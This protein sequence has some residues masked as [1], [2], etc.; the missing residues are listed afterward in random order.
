MTDRPTND[1]HDPASAE[2]EPASSPCLEAAAW[3]E[4]LSL[5]A[6]PFLML[7]SLFFPNGSPGMVACMVLAFACLVNGIAINNLVG[8]FQNSAAPVEPSLSPRPA[9]SAAPAGLTP[10]DVDRV[11]AMV[12]EVSPEA[13]AQVHLLLK[14]HMS[15]K[16]DGL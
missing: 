14:G 6:M 8:P 15:E 11:L 13:R 12:P 2:N 7:A 10:D 16:Q 4:G 3:I 1:H 9:R 5:L